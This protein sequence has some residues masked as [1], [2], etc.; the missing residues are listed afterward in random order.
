MWAQSTVCDCHD[1][2]KDAPP[3]EDRFSRRLVH[4]HVL[5]EIPFD[6]RS[7]SQLQQ[8]R[9]VLFPLVDERSD[10]PAEKLFREELCAFLL[11][12]IRSDQTW[13]GHVECVASALVEDARHAE[14]VADQVGASIAI[15]EHVP[16]PAQLTRPIAGL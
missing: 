13:I 4:D 9:F 15:D 16:M 3:R 14:D 2:G 7:C 5:V 8:R 6:E 10:L 1:D 12:E 11:V